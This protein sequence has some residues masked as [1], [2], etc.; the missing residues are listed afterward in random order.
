MI[1][2]FFALTILLLS[3][4]ACA[5]VMMNGEVTSDKGEALG[6]V[7]MSAFKQRGLKTYSVKAQLPDET[8]F[9]GEMHFGEKTVTL[10]SHD[11]VSM[12]CE[13]AMKKQAEEFE[14][15]GTGSCSTSDGQKMKVK[16]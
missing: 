10:Y 7:E 12:N 1:Y 9:N 13:F 6:P 15:G 5:P 2:R 3:L 14:G 16:F 11:G 8:V 4:A